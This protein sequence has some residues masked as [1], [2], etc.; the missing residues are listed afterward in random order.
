MSDK[1][2]ASGSRDLAQEPLESAAMARLHIRVSDEE[3]AALQ[4]E[5][6]RQGVD[7]SAVVRQGLAFYLGWL[8]SRREDEK[9]SEKPPNG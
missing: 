7:L 8:E 4:E 9:P 3:K 6:E 1:G 2:H 5:A